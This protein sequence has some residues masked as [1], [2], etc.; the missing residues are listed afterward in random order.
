LQLR[1]RAGTHFLEVERVGNR[2]DCERKYKKAGTHFLEVER[3]SNKSDCNCNY[4]K[5][6]GRTRW[7]SRG[8]AIGQIVIATTKGAGTYKLEVERVNNRS[9]CD[10]TR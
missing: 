5:G 3:T 2:S 4:K 9:D 8:S 6:H 7:G 10:P 1:K